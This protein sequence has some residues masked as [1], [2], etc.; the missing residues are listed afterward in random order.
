MTSTNFWLQRLILWCYLQNISYSKIYIYDYVSY[1]F[2]WSNGKYVLQRIFN[3]DLKIHWTQANEQ[4]FGFNYHQTFYIGLYL[5][6]KCCNMPVLITVLNFSFFILIPNRICWKVMETI[7]SALPKAN[8]IPFTVKW[9]L[10][11]MVFTATICG[12]VHPKWA[13]TTFQLKNTEF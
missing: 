12:S 11:R 3:I 9:T 4:N 10:K 13:L 1:E 8:L 2:S 7:W 5:V 6:I